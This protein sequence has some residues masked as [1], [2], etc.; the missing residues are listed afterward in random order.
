MA[1][2]ITASLDCR[3]KSFIKNWEMEVS[4]GLQST[5]VKLLLCTP[6][7][8]AN[9]KTKIETLGAVLDLLQSKNTRDTWGYD[10]R[11][12]IAA[13]KLKLNEAEA[14]QKKAAESLL[15]QKR[16]NRDLKGY[17][18]HVQTA[19]KTSED[20]EVQVNQ[21]SR[22]S[23]EYAINIDLRSKLEEASN[24]LHRALSQ[25]NT[26][27]PDDDEFVLCNT[28]PY[29]PAAEIAASAESLSSHTT[30]SDELKDPGEDDELIGKGKEEVLCLKI[31][32]LQQIV[33]DT[34]HQVEAT[35]KSQRVKIAQLETEVKRMEKQLKIQRE[36]ARK[37]LQNKER[38]W[39]ERV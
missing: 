31:S 27:A 24:Q 8:R 5:K 28:E 3:V 29:V 14:K 10:Q 13:L 32:R 39:A 11:E 34:V 37:A 1:R 7:E 22:L 36:E 9:L 25:M 20:K 2:A 26:K 19:K 18:S 33:D 23:P 4:K 35:L 16:I 17:C 12:E 38:V 30:V 15:A 6:H 21:V